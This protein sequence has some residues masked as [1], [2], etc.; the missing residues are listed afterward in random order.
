MPD[1]AQAD[2]ACLPEVDEAD[3]PDAEEP[4]RA[5]PP[6]GT[7]A[8]DTPLW[9]CPLCS[10]QTPVRG[11]IDEPYGDGTCERHPRQSLRLLRQGG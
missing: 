4:E 5:L 3:K 11:T 2:E 6:P 9:I 1:N 8:M 7:L 10:E